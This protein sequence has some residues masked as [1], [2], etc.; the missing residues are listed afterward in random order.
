ME[1]TVY[2]AFAE[3][4]DEVM[5]DVD[6]ANW[7]RHLVRLTKKFDL[8]VEKILDLACGT[9]GHAL[10]LSSMGYEVTGLDRSTTMLRIAREKQANVKVE[11]DWREGDMDSFSS[12][13]LNTDFDLVT[14]LYDSLNYILEEKDVERCFQEVYAHLRPGGGYIFDVTTEYNL[15]QNFSGYTF[16]E[17]FETASYIWEND[18]DIVSKICSS[19]VT[20]FY[21]NNGYYDK[22]V[23]VHTQKVYPTNLL[24]KL[25]QR[26][27][28]E[29]ADIYHNLTEKPVQQECERIHFVCFK[30]NSK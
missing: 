9:G 2:N 6:Y 27:G 28:F 12:V 13:G 16:A 7:A 17:N 11:V 14:C 24:K 30:P 19:K 23:E 20:V 1:D 4:Y 10:R 3:I 18:Y 29:V 5:R 8:H 21:H 25:L 22:H 15:L 26:T